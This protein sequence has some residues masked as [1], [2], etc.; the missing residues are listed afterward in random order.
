M[1]SFLLN[2]EITTIDQARADLTLLEYLREQQKLTGTKEGCG[3]GDCGA[4]T[5]VLA[6]VVKNNDAPNNANLEYRAINSCVTFLSALHGKQLITVEHLPDGKELHPVQQSLVE[7]HGSQCGFCTPGFIMSMFALYQKTQQPDREAVIQALSGNLCR[8]TGYRPIID[9]TLSACQNKSA[10]KFKQTEPQTV[11]RLNDIN[12]E[13]IST[14]NLLVPTSR[15]ELAA[16]KA[17]Y[18]NANVFAGSTDLALQVT[19]QLK[20]FDKLIALGGVPELNQLVEQPQGLLIGA[21]LPLGKIESS[22]L[23]HFPQ[24]SELLWRFAATP[25]RNQASLGG[26]VA[27]ASP[28]GDMPPA[29]LA[30]NA[31]IHVDDGQQKR[32]ILASD[33]F[34]DYRK[35]ALKTSE[36]IESIYIPFTDNTN[37]LRAYKISK[38]YEDDISAVCAVFNAKIIDGKIQSIHS[39]FGGVAAIPATVSALNSELTGKTWSSKETFEIGNNILKQ[40]FSPL[41]DVRASKTYRIAMLSNLWKRFWLETNQCAQKIET[42]VVHIP[43]PSEEIRHA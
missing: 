28:I 42:R 12:N 29:L 9:A 5:V 7:Y 27:N 13:I 33:F 43:S 17:K 21:A 4:C 26:N 38:R 20:S 34:L 30:L 16:A 11:K 25:I 40:A 8:C 14:D 39:G 41:D 22:L 3:S 19:Q 24:L 6:E 35:T 10:D 15:Q 2:N 37:L 18:P 1:I 31:V 36:W 23:K 32:T